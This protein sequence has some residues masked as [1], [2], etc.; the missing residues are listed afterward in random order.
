LR[1]GSLEKTNFVLLFCQIMACY[2]FLKSFCQGISNG[3][4]HFEF[5]EK[6]Y[7]LCSNKGFKSAYFV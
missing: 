6:L 2:M 7:E 1:V 5:Q 4:L 3:I